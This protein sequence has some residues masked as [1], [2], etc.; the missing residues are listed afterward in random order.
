MKK[1]FLLF[2]LLLGG[3][4]YS[5]CTGH[6]EDDA[7]LKKVEA[8][9]TKLLEEKTQLEAKI[10]EPGNAEKHILEEQDLELLR[11]RLERLNEKLKQLK[12]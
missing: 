12:N 11:S 6:P 10:K 8:E 7:A 2:L 3:L 1:I 4:T 5:A 9:V